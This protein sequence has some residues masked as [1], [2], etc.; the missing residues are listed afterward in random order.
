MFCLSVVVPNSR[1]PVRRAIGTGFVISENLLATAFHVKDDLDKSVGNFTLQ[2]AQIIAW[3]KLGSGVYVQI[4][5]KFK[6]ADKISDMALYSFDA[7]IFKQQM[8]TSEIKFLTLAGRLPQ[9]GED[10]L[11]ISYYGTMGYPFNSLGNVSMIDNGE[12]IYSDLTLMPGNSDSPLVSMKTGEVLGVNTKVMTLGDS[13]LRL[14][15]ARRI[16][17][18][19]KLVENS[20]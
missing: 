2:K 14:G 10:I 17:D 11:S 12:D 6:T 15:I 16:S 19:K 7:E 13:T 9:I 4:P 3:K 5:L 8:K 1:F 20:R 18:L